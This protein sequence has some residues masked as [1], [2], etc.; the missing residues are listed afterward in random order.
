MNQSYFSQKIGLDLH[1]HQIKERVRGMLLQICFLKDFS[2][3]MNLS[4]YLIMIK[5]DLIKECSYF[6]T[7]DSS[8]CSHETE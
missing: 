2:E 8:L 5:S 4:L 7:I 3:S 1:F 6:T